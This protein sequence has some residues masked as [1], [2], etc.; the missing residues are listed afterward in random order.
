MVTDD[1]YIGKNVF[2]GEN[3]TLGKGTMIYDNVIIGDNV[4]TGKLCVI[5]DNVYIGNNV[6]LADHVWIQNSYIGDNSKLENFTDIKYSILFDTINTK[7]FCDIE[8]CVIEGN[9]AFGMERVD[10]KIIGNNPP[11]EKKYAPITAVEQNFQADFSV[12]KE[13]ISQAVFFKKWI[14]KNLQNKIS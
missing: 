5:K 10:G 7:Q 3:V 9:R 6:V 2:I 12:L 1:Y 11:L 13:W 8:N 4:T 14:K